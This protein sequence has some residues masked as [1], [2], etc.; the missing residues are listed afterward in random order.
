MDKKTV[1]GWTPAINQNPSADLIAA[2]YLEYVNDYLSITAWGE[3]HH[4]DFDTAALFINR[5]QEIH[6]ARASI[7]KALPNNKNP[8]L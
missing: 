3:A 6:N 5:A 8:H 2:L 1:T 7:L 4:M